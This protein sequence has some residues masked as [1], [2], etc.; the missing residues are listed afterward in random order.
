[1]YKRQ[2]QQYAQFVALAH[3]G[4]TPYR[5]QFRLMRYVAQ[6]GRWPDRISVPTASGKTSV[7]DIHVFLNAMVGLAE[8]ESRKEHEILSCLPLRLIPRRLALTV[9]RRSLVD[10]QFDEADELCGKIHTSESMIHYKEGLKLRAGVH[11]GLPHTDKPSVMNVVELRGGLAY[12]RDWRYYPQTCAV[13]CATPDMFGSRLLFRGYGTSRTM[14]SMEAG[15]LAYDTVLVADEAHLSRQLLETAQ[16]VDRIES[17]ADYPLSEYVSPLQVVETTATPASEGAKRTS[18]EIEQEDLTVD[19]SLADRLCKPKSVV[20]D[21]TSATEKEEIQKIVDICVGMIQNQESGEYGETGNG[22]VGCIVNTVKKAKQVAKE[23]STQLKK[24][25]I[26]RP[27]ASYIG[28]MRAYDKK[29]SLRQCA[30]L[31]R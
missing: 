17:M 8:D 4:R 18:V 5:W 10:D 24:A 21:C 1:M 26:S 30:M 22:V 31:C 7:I 23:L 12:Q 9:N 13:I 28:P 19:T 15:L 3:D 29:K 11:D 20:L 14:R 16:Q 6:E 25:G 2:E 27:V